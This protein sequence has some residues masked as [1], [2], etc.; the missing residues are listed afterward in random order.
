VC[1][2]AAER[3]TFGQPTAHGDKQQHKP[4]VSAGCQGTGVR[5]YMC[6]DCL[7]LKV[8]VACGG[9]GGRSWAAGAA[10]GLAAATLEARM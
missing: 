4:S 7:G 9:Q 5:V 2:A 10:Y 1:E 3:D 8:L 6:Y